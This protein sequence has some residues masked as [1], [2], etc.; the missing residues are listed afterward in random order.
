MKKVV[1]SLVL[2]ILAIEF[3]PAFS[4]SY[5]WAITTSN[6]PRSQAVSLRQDQLSNIYLAS[7]T[8]SSSI[9]V[10]SQIEKRDEQQ[11]MIWQLIFPGNVTISDMEINSSGMLIAAGYFQDTLSVDTFILVNNTGSNTGFICEIT[12]QGMVNWLHE[13]NPTGDDFKPGD[14]FISSNGSMYITS[15]LSGGTGVNCA[16]HQLDVNGNI[17]QTEIGANFDNRTFSHILADNNGNVYL[18]GTCGNMAIFDALTA[19]PS[20]SYQN[21]LVK[22]DS[23]FTAQW[24]LTKEYITFDNN[25]NIC[26]DGQK[27]FWVYDE[28]FPTSVDTVKIST[29]DFNGNELNNF[30]GPLDIAFF[31]GVDLAVDSSGNSVLALEA[32][33]RTFLFRYDSQF[34]MTWQ[35]T[36]YT[37]ISSFPFY[38][39][40][41]CYDSSFYISSM[42]ISD[43][44]IADNFTLLNP[45]SGSNFPSDIFI[46]KW[47]FPQINGVQEVE[48]SSVHLFPNPVS[49]K[50]FILSSDNIRYS[51]FSIYNLLGK[52]IFRDQYNGDYIPV[53]EISS[54]MYI[55][56]LNDGTKEQTV[57]FV[58]Q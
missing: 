13:I 38:N 6:S 5:Q 51:R 4:Q 55:L 25:N 47:G 22:Y 14:L 52:E 34:N 33:T 3:T 43:T 53:E 57:K 42:Y 50:L 21:F 12:P 19:N 32:F 24:I 26:S 11:N 7:F 16:F 29:V 2:L 45:N 23:T 56:K 49:D 40:L 44:L 8:D 18:S 28:S 30:A 9:R 37:R 15:Q 46:C 39:A 41:V 54:G 31:P 36:L 27:L 20:F 17:L 48:N 35:D 58:R 10:H 1:Y